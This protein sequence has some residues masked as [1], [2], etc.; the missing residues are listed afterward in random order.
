MKEFLIRMSE[1]TGDITRLLTAIDRNAVLSGRFT[2]SPRMLADVLAVMTGDILRFGDVAI[3]NDGTIRVD[4]AYGG[5]SLTYTLKILMFSVA[6]GAID[7]RISYTEQRR[8]GGVGGAF[9][10]LTGKSGLGVALSKYRGIKVTD[11]EILVSVRGA[12]R[13]LHAVFH[14]ASPEGLQFRVS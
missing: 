11:R 6:N 12:P 4:I 14:S 13:S 2:V 1:H 7:G 8:G 5:M 3:A 9:L 10:G